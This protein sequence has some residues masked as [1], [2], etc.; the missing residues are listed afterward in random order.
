[1]GSEIL[2]Q[3][4]EVSIDLWIPYKTVVEELMPNAQVV[5]DSFHVMKQINQELY[6]RRKKGSSELAGENVNNK[7]PE[8]LAVQRIKAFMKHPNSHF[9]NFYYDLVIE[10][11]SAISYMVSSVEPKKREK[12]SRKIK[13]QKNKRA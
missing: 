11:L 1:L 2:N 8:M 6:A 9:I 4:E 13:N 12:S 7:I 10:R 3:I 5:A